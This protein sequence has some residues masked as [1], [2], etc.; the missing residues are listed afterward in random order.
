M[1]ETFKIAKSRRIDTNSKPTPSFAIVFL[2]KQYIETCS[3]T[4]GAF[5]SPDSLKLC[6]FWKAYALS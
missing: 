3:Q 5:D 1:W 4:I 6:L 2:S